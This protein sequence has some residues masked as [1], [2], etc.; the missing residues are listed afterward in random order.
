MIR[1]TLAACLVVLSACTTLQEP[2]VPTPSTGATVSPTLIGSS[3]P[4]ASPTAATAVA[5]P[6]LGPLPASGYEAFALGRLGGDWAFTID[7][8]E[9]VARLWAVPLNGGPAKLAARY[10]RASGDGGVLGSQFAPD[11]KRL[12]LVVGAP[13][14]SGGTRASLVVL[15]LET[16][17]VSAL[18][19]DDADGDY[20]PAWSPDGQQ[21]AYVRRLDQS[22]AA[23]DDGIWLMRT[24]GTGVRQLIPGRAGDST[25]LFGWT[26]NGSHVAFAYGKERTYTLVA[27]V[28]DAQLRV[29]SGYVASSVDARSF[30]WRVAAPRFAGVFTEQTGCVPRYL[31]VSDGRGDFAIVVRE[32]DQVACSA[33]LRNVRWHPREDA[34]LYFRDTVAIEL[35]V[36][37]LSGADQGV[38]I[39]R[40]PRMAEWAS[41][42]ARIVYAGLPVGECCFAG[43]L[44]VV[45]RDGRGERV[46]F[47]S[48]ARALL[49]D[50]A[51]RGY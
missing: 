4:L 14:P 21:L 15:D 29:G 44:R 32:P 45:D 18:G 43:D 51:V 7:G 50:L 24:D 25:Q 9:P 16:G 34:L 46:I 8:S 41:D 47:A 11:G 23:F 6:A 3:P 28:S 48:A 13:R 37:T 19:R 27:L 31:G 33:S 36:A 20:S 40:R 17:R 2:A 39:S 30:S 12:V 5:V 1:L 38:P 42:G 49:V 35:R 22:T 10:R 26:A